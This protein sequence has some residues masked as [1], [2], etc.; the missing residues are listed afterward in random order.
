[1][2][3]K[4]NDKVLVLQD[5]DENMYGTVVGYGDVFI[6]LG[7]YPLDDEIHAPERFVIV[8]LD[9]QHHGNVY[10][11]EVNGLW[12]DENVR[13]T[14]NYI[15]TVIV[16]ADNLRPVTWYVN[17]VIVNRVYLGPEE[18]GRYGDAVEVQEVSE[19]PTK[20]EASA[21][22][23]KFMA[24]IKDD[25]EWYEGGGMDTHVYVNYKPAENSFP[26]RAY[27]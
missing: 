19:Y 5:D 24:S 3:F 9:L 14:A 8:H 18:G 4:I 26:E 2:D 1:M 17:H 13:R 6:P 23:L 27:R 12:D 25:G 15:D 21:A 7:R 16:H 20:N 22:C 11:A 10:V